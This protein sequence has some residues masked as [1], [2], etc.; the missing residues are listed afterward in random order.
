MGVKASQDGVDVVFLDATGTQLERLFYGEHV[1]FFSAPRP[2]DKSQS[3]PLF[4]SKDWL[5]DIVI[6]DNPSKLGDLPPSQSQIA[7]TSAASPRVRVQWDVGGGEQGTQDLSLTICY[8]DNSGGH[9]FVD[10]IAVLPP[11]TEMTRG[12]N[13]YQD[14]E[15]ASKLLLFSSNQSASSAKSAGRRHRRSKKRKSLIPVSTK[16]QKPSGL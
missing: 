16:R 6:L 15:A 2:I 3:D 14:W 13:L 8:G 7:A 5:T 10:E 11:G 12:H 1:F 9:F 4:G